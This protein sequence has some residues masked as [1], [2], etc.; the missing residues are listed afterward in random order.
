MKRAMTKLA[1][2]GVTCTLAGT[3]ASQAVVP[4]D[5]SLLYYKIGGGEPVSRP[6]NPAATPLRIG[7]GGSARLNYSCGRFDGAVTIQNLMNG[8]AS[9]GTTVTSAVRSGIAALPLYVL[10]RASPGL[11]ELFQTYQKKAE[12]EWNIALKT[13]EEM[14][15]QIKQGGDPYAE[16]L[17]MAKGEG[18]KEVSRTTRDAVSAKQRVETSGGVGGLT[19]IGGATIL[20]RVIARMTPQCARLVLNANGDPARF[21]VTG[22]PVVPD[23]VPDFAGPLAGIL[24]GLDWAASHAGDIADVVSVPGDCPFLPPDLVGRLHRARSEAGLPLA[25]ARSGDWRHPVIGL[26]PVALRDDLRRVLTGEHSV[27]ALAAKYDMSFAAVQKH[28]AVLEKAGLLTKRRR[29]RE[30]LAT[31][32]VEAVRS[33]AS[34]LTELEQVWRGRIARIDLLIAAEPDQED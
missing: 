25:C 22:L 15:A 31:G 1:I 14:E 33:V 5:Q 8:F 4:G 17:A 12:T 19:W 10:Q 21:A 30:Q 20:D 2:A 23:D 29:G 13:C 28:V 16:W 7:L 32:D 9:L 18:W 3:A 27:S 6:A 34:M 11:Y 26:W 24:A